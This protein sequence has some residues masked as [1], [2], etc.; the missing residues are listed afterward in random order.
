LATT[1]FATS[2]KDLPQAS[3]WFKKAAEQGHPDAQF[4]LAVMY[5]TGEGVPA[6]LTESVQWMRKAADQGDPTAQFNLGMMYSSGKG[7]PKDPVQAYMWAGLAAAAGDA[8]PETPRRPAK[9]S[10]ARSDCRRPAE[11]T[12]M[13]TERAIFLEC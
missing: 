4:N 6:N 10:N 3:Q 5:L 13:E 2:P 12:R 7:V 8:I 11:R 1:H 9:N